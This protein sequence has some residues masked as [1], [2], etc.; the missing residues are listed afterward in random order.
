VAGSGKWIAQYNNINVPTAMVID[1]CLEITLPKNS[2]GK[3]VI[4]RK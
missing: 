2:S 1:G 4:K 3:L